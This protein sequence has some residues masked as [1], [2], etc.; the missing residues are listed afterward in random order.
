MKKIISLLLFIL[1]TVSLMACSNNNNSD[2]YTDT[3]EK[4]YMPVTEKKEITQSEAISLAK[5]D[6]TVNYFIGFTNFLEFYSIS[7][8]TCTAERNDDG[9]TVYLKGNV[10]GYT[11]EYKTNYKSKEKFSIKVKVSFD[12]YVGYPSYN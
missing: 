6:D 4:E 9:W 7:W 11:D 2:I 3:D 8:G 1:L 5:N 12:G 10:S